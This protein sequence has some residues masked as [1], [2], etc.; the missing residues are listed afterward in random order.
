MAGTVHEPPP[1]PAGTLRL[2]SG[3]GIH[4][5]KLGQIS[6][7]QILETRTPTDG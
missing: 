2:P 3:G 7:F 1:E 5:I 4:I 6:K